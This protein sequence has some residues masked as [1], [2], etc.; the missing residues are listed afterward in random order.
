MNR[1]FVL[2][3]EDSAVRIE[4]RKIFFTIVEIKDYSV[5]IYRE[6]FFHQTVRNSIKTYGNAREFASGRGDGY[7]TGS[8]PDY[9]HFKEKL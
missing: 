9:P 1:F 3:F 2:S 4:R 5:I 6:I 8:P 7:A